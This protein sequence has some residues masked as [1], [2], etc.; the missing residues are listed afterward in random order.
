MHFLGTRC[1]ERVEDNRGT[2]V[3]TLISNSAQ[4]SVKKNEI[5]PDK[6]KIAYMRVTVTQDWLVYERDVDRENGNPVV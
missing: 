1:Y 3:L 5:Q 4:Q 6:Q 2:A